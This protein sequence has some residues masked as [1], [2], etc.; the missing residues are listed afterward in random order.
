M[1]F[2]KEFQEDIYWTS[3]MVCVWDKEDFEKYLKEVDIEGV[4]LF[5]DTAGI[6]L[7]EYNLL[8]V[9]SFNIWILVHELSHFAICSLTHRGININ[10]K[11]QEPF[12][13][14]IQYYIDC[15]YWWINNIDLT[16]KKKNDNWKGLKTSSK[17]QKG[18]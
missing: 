10:Y 4:E 14:F 17:K 6:Y 12:C 15:I 11:N 9:S 2:R 7:P 3:I 8:W 1:I 18:S 5:H 13:Y 16:T